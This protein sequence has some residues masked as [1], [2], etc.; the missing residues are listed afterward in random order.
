VWGGGIRSLPP[1]VPT[2]ITETKT[3]TKS[4]RLHPSEKKGQNQYEKMFQISSHENS[5]WRV[6]GSDS[7]CGKEK[8]KG[9]LK[10]AKRGVGC[11]K[12]RFG[13]DE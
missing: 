10:H 13:C 3:T 4:K 5:T 1:S 9:S 6:Q 12:M 7:G 8:H 2:E 11:R